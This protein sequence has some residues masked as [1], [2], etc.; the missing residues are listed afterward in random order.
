MPRHGP[1]VGRSGVRAQEALGVPT[2]RVLHRH[3]LEEPVPSRHPWTSGVASRD[4]VARLLLAY[5]CGHERE[6]ERECDRRGKT[7]RGQGTGRTPLS[8]A[9]GSATSV[10][11]RGAARAEPSAV[12]RAWEQQTAAWPSPVWHRSV[13]E[14]STTCADSACA[15]TSCLASRI[16]G[17]SSRS[18]PSPRG[19]GGRLLEGGRDPRARAARL[20]RRRHLRQP[21]Q[22]PKPQGG[23]QGAGPARRYLCRTQAPRGRLRRLPS[24]LPRPPAALWSPSRVARDQLVG[25]PG[26][27]PAP[28]R[29]VPTRRAGDRSIGRLRIRS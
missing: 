27:R 13:V 24:R 15:R 3:P 2:R 6:R 28:K 10:S 26:R 21:A 18:E 22:P 12:P 14:P 29:S 16:R 4:V 19:R 9:G 11:R 20:P 5:R 23:E 17:C 8:R 25:E 1:T 7:G